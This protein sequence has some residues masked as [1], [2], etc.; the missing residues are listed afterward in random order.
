[1]EKEDIEIIINKNNE[2]LIDPD[3]FA[4]A[5]ALLGIII[6]GGSYLETRRNRQFLE[7]QAREE[8]RTVWFR[9]KRTLIHA[10]R[11]TEEFATYVKEESFGES[12]FLFGTIKLT[13]DQDKAQQFRRIHGNAQTTAMHMADDLDD[14][15]NYLSSEYQER[16]DAIQSKIKEQMVPHSYDAVLILA[17]DTIDLYEK[18]ITDI[19]EKEKFD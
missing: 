6:A 10:K 7:R 15:S 14:L 12:E 16:I 18:L 19:G 17:R 11:I 4:I 3:P 9:A 5:F 13:I 8:F 1:M 2:E